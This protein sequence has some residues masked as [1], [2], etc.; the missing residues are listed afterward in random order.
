[1]RKLMDANAQAATK[2]QIQAV[3]DNPE[4]SKSKKMIALFELGLPVK[5]IHELMGVRY[6][7][8]YNVVSNYC[9]MNGIATESTVKDGKK[10]QIIA[11]FKEGKSLKEIA[12]E[13]KTNYNYVFNVV[14]QYKKENG[15]VSKKQAT[16]A[17][18]E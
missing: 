17:A 11:L 14:K 10:D 4:L 5:D 2:A 3:L 7:F 12:I 16:E 1:M 6:N 13:L 9:N 15:I 8:V 18:N